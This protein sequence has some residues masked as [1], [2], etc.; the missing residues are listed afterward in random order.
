M[1]NVRN[2]NDANDAVWRKLGVRKVLSFITSPNRF[3]WF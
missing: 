1:D 2:N 3:Q